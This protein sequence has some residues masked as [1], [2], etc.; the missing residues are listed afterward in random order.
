M[1]SEG[2]DIPRLRVGAYL[3]ITKAELFFRQ[4][5]GRF[6]RVLAHLQYQDAYIFIPKDKEIVKLAKEIQ[7]EREH[8]LDKVKNSSN[9]FGS[10]A[11]L[12][13]GTYTPALKGRF[14]PVGSTLLGGDILEVD[15][16]I[17][18]G[19]REEVVK[20]ITDKSPVY[21]QKEALRKQLGA[22]AKRYALKIRNGNSNI[23]PDW[24]AAHKLWKENGGKEM[25]RETIPELNKRL[26]FYKNLLRTH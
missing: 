20:T 9:G 17:S 14:Q 19:M 21:L 8:A 24:K 23:K 18:S 3:T 7:E 4:A 6:V 1:V 13:G 16:G 5:I 15:V 10:N 2:V 12:F 22:L 11:D 26:A 25:G